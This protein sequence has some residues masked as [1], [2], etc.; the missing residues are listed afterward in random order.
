[1][2]RRVV[3]L[4]TPSQSFAVGRD[5]DHPRSPVGVGSFACQGLQPPA[6]RNGVLPRG[7]RPASRP[8][9]PPDHDGP[10]IFR[11]RANVFHHLPSAGLSRRGDR[12]RQDGSQISAGTPVAFTTLQN[13]LLFPIVA[14]MRVF[15]AVQT[16]PCIVRPESLNTSICACRSP[17]HPAQSTCR[18]IPYAPASSSR[19][20]LSATPTP[21]GRFVMPRSRSS[22]VSSPRS[23]AP[24]RRARRRCRIS[25][26]AAMT[27]MAAAS[28]STATAY[29]D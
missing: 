17:T 27:S 24:A 2:T 20:C 19:T 15:I 1:M 26:L 10:I 29:A 9:S 12:S 22:Q 21:A 4:F 16:V 14:L 11:G 18:I 25:F 13:R 23:L 3:G 28:R 6:L 7:E 8:A 5:G